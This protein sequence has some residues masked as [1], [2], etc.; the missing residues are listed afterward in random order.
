M[1]VL[2]K[3]L[4][5]A[6]A[7]LEK[8]VPK[9]SAVDSIKNF[10]AKNG[11]LIATDLETMVMTDVPGLEGEFLLPRAVAKLLK[12]IPAMEMLEITTSDGLSIAWSTGKTRMGTDKAADYAEIRE[13]TDTTTVMVEGDELIKAMCECLPYAAQEENRPT[14]TG[15][16]LAPVE[17]GVE[18]VGADGFRMGVRTVKSTLLLGHTII[19]PKRSIELIDAIWTR[20]R[21]DARENDS[22]IDMLLGKRKLS[23]TTCAAG[24]R[25]QFGIGKVT[26]MAQL[27]QGNFPDYTKLEPTSFESTVGFFSEDMAVALRRLAVADNATGLIRMNWE[28]KKMVITSTG[29]D[30]EMSEE[31]KAN[32]DTPGKIALNQK[33]LAEVVR[34]REGYITMS[35]QGT[36]P[37]KFV[38]RGSPAIL[39]MPMFVGSDSKAKGAPAESPKPPENEVEPAIEEE[40]AEVVEGGDEEVA[41]ES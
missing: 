36:G 6:L 27:I 35:V 28:E 26:V 21:T 41:V 18:V 33:Y 32:T 30:S 38:H 1:K 29:G 5:E 24:T 3:N 20:T 13:M 17:G 2:N 11:K 15:V 16:A 14:L 12:N 8:A 40:V 31:I 23:V 37:I 4:S 25:I 10:L 22:L 34:D 9:K 7:L 39:V 19:L